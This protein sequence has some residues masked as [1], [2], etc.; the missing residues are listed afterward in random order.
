[1]KFLRK[2]VSTSGHG[3]LALEILSPLHPREDEVQV[4]RGF[5]GGVGIAEVDDEVASRA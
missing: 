5:H 3:N 2:K 4:V 1:M